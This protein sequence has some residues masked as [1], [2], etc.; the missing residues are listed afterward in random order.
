MMKRIKVLQ[1]LLCLV[2]LAGCNVNEDCTDGN[3]ILFN[4]TIYTLDGD[5]PKAD[6]MVVNGNKI[7]FVGQE[8]NAKTFQAN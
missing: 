1:L 6:S 3:I 2:L 5:N 7:S 8:E 4:S